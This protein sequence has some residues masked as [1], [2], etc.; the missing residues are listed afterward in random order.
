V[1]ELKPL[2]STRSYLSRR[3][4]DELGALQ[5]NVRALGATRS[6]ALRLL[7]TSRYATTAL[8]QREFWMEFSLLDEE[9]RAALRR[10][11]RFCLQHRE[12]ARPG[13]SGQPWADPARAGGLSSLG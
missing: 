11:A 9:Y 12:P 6:T 4:L 7:I 2:A 10:L 13:V 5:G 3:A 1:R 8:A